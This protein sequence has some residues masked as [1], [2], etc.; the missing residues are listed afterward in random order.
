MEYT[1]INA[2]WLRNAKQS[3]LFFIKGQEWWIPYKHFKMLDTDT[4]E[5]DQEYLDKINTPPSENIDTISL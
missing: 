3:A 1:P 4:I 2:K 5:V